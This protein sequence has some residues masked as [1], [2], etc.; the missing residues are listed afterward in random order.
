MYKNFYIYTITIIET[1]L[2]KITFPSTGTFAPGKTLRIS[3]RCTSSTGILRSLVTSSCSP[4][5]TNVASVA[6]RLNNRA[7][8]SDVLPYGGKYKDELQFT[9]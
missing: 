8:A 6:W 4:S 2:R 9:F 7:R 1:V 3:P 5:S